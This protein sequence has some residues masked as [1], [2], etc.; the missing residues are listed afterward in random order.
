MAHRNG[1]EA[2]TA[3]TDLDQRLID[4]ARWDFGDLNAVYPAHGNQVVLWD[5]GCRFDYENPEPRA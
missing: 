2:L 1:R 3:L 4:Q 5:A